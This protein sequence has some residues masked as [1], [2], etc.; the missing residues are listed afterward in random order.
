MPRI[1]TETLVHSLESLFDGGSVGGLSD[2]QLL[3]RFNAA[4]DAAG[5]AAFAA[6]VARHGRMVLD[7]CHQLLGDVH[8]AED[9]FQAVFFVLARKAPSIREP[10]LLANWLYGV[11]LRTARYAKFQVDH[12][13]VKEGADAM[14][15]HGPGK[16]AALVL[17][18]R[19]PEQPAIDREE[20]EALHREINRLPSSFRLPVVLCYFEGLTLDEAARRLNCPAGTLRSRLARA[21]EKLRRGLI[22]RGIALPAGTVAAALAPRSAGASVSSHLCETTT[23]AAIGFVAGQSGAPLAVSL[24]REVLRSMVIHKVKAIS[25]TLLLLGAFATSAGYLTRSLARNNDP[26]RSAAVTPDD[27]NPKPAAGRM[28]VVGRV[29]DP[30]GKAVP[31]ASV[32]AAARIKLSVGS[33]GLRRLAATM[34][35]HVDADGSGRF[36]LDAPRTSSSRNDEFMAIALAPGY[37]AGWVKIDPDADQPVAD[38]SLEPE[39]VI[40][41]RLFDVQGRPAQGVVVSVCRIHRDLV[42]DPGRPFD[43]SRR[44]D[45]PMFW[46]DR[47][48]DLPAWPKPAT[49]D[50]NGLFTIHGVGRGLRARMS[51]IDPRFAS[52]MIDVETDDAPGA[53][54]LKTVLQPAKIFT[55]RVTY[56]D[57]GKPVPHAQLQVMASGEGQLGNR[58]TE[59]RTE[60]DG[61]FRVNPSPGDRFTI[62][63]TPPAGQL[64]LTASKRVDWPKG[65]VEQS[66]DLALP[67]GVTI[68]GKVI[69]EGSAH[70]VSGALVDFRSQMRAGKASDDGFSEASTAEDGSFA[71]A[72]PPGAGHLAVQAPNEDYVLREIGNREFF[73][74]QSGGTRLYSH[75]FVACEVKPPGLEVRVTLRRGATVT[76]LIVGPD[77]EPVR[78][79]W[80]IGR[81]AIQTGPTAWRL[82]QGEHHGTATG[83][84]FELHGLD[85]DSDVTVYFLQPARRLGATAR[86]SGKLAAGE[87]K[88]VRLEPCGTA[89]GRLVDA[90]H[91][92]IAGYGDDDLVVMIITP[93]PELG[94]RDP[95]DAKR[96]SRQAAWLFS[97]DPI[98]YA[99]A[100]V[101]DSQGRIAFPALIPGA[102]YRVTERPA[103]RPSTG[104]PAHKD[105]S[106]KSGETL[107]LGDILI[108]KRL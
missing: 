106:V 89:T 29:L 88:T 33:V 11:A 87:A 56:A 95:A 38:I 17:V 105:F 70:P 45:G 50:S 53:K 1:A 84:R 79:V 57:T 58:P 20:A 16:S 43:G 101:A 104:P 2:R 97:I 71:L 15:H 59:F 44:P 8:H 13:R 85:P 24:A 82:W 9:A 103:V 92:P 49:T 27:A 91:R 21:R 37:G 32:M 102:T 12:R 55:G 99:K 100:P 10:D 66:L 78:D 81:A 67:R 36:R 94:A 75:S 23:R 14:R 77:G 54:L 34:I 6:L 83:G 51:V 39:Q 64:Y 18:G 108:E 4:R 3:E 76:G 25:L 40:E 107:D 48:T 31:R 7:L 93:G 62:R 80:I 68:H 74:G 65:A 26:P 72:A 28:F 86:F 30:R 73:D 96:L 90:G 61:R 5:E 63:A 60:A 22:R 42:R 46:W 52:Q 35:G 41:G 47:V 98:N 19:P 69:E